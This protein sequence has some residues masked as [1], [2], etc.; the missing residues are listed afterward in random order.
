MLSSQI[1]SASCEEEEWNL[2]P[3]PCGLARKGFSFLLAL[4]S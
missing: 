4:E 3:A 2:G 1:S